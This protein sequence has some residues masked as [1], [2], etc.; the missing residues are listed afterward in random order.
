MS[1]IIDVVKHYLE[2]NELVT[3]KVDKI[4]IIVET[5]NEHKHHDSDTCQT[6]LS[7][8]YDYRCDKEC[9]EKEKEKLIEKLTHNNECIYGAVSDVGNNPKPKPA[10]I[11]RK[12]GVLHNCVYKL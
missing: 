1:K 3:G 12:N 9:E 8:E 7:K 2:R 5:L 11:V 6:I 10:Y 4:S